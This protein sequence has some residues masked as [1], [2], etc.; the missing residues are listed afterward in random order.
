VYSEG[1]DDDA[2][3]LPPSQ[4]NMA[5]YTFLLFILMFSPISGPMRLIPAS[6]IGC[7]PVPFP[8]LRFCNPILDSTVTIYL[9]LEF[10]AKFADGGERYA[11]SDHCD[12]DLKVS[13]LLAT[14]ITA[15]RPPVDQGLVY[16]GR[17]R[18][19]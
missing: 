5:D 13:L 1:F 19:D 15:L 18:V 8:S 12:V 10:G 4:S 9:V 3:W 14:T 7:T 16:L 11:T 17:Q 6:V 2:A